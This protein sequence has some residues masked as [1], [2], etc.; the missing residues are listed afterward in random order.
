MKRLFACI[1]LL[2]ALMGAGA[3][4]QAQA[5]IEIGPR[6]GFDLAG[7]VEEFFLGA[8]GRL[9]LAVLPITLNAALDFYFPDGFDFF[10]LSL[11]ALYEFGPNNR[12]FT[13]YA[14]LGLGF[15][16]AS[17]GANFT[18][19]TDVGLNLIGG[20]VL[21]TGNLRPFAQAQITFGD[22]DLVTVAGGLLFRVGG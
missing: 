14:G 18:D 15:S 21:G 8:D 6:A 1:A 5:R 11:N 10:Q 12:V 16:R 22:A 13:P 2:V 7:D 17:G 9:G 19:N 3:T 4:A 20:A